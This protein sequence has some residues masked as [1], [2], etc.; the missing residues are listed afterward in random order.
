MQQLKGK[1]ITIGLEKS[2]LFL[3]AILLV[4]LIL[5]FACL[6][7]LKS[8][9]LSGFFVADAYPYDSLALEILK[10]NLFSRDFLYTYPVYPFFVSIVYYIFGHSLI[11]VGVIQI[12]LDALT[13]ILLY[14]ICL[15]IFNKKSIALLAFFM[16]ACYGLAILY[17]G[18]LVAVTLSIFINVLLIWVLIPTM[19]KKHPVHWLFSGV[20]LGLSFLITANTIIFL[21]F[22]VIWS[23]SGIKKDTRKKITN[24]LYLVL[25]ICITLAPFSLRNYKIEKNFSPFPAQGGLKFYIGNNPQARGIYET[26]NGISKV[27]ITDVKDSIALAEKEAKKDFNSFQAS[28]YWSKKGLRFIA[29]HPFIFLDLVMRK[30]ILFWNNVEFAPNV[31][32]YFCST[33]LPVLKLPL[34]S[35]GLIAPFSILGIIFVFTQKQEKAY[36]VI[37]LIFAYILYAII[38][39][40]ADRYRIPV[41]PFL[42][43]LASYAVYNFYL[44]ARNGFKRELIG[45]LV[46]LFVLFITINSDFY[47]INPK[48]SFTTARRNLG[49]VYYNLGNVYVSKAMMTEAVEHYQKAIELNP[50]FTEAYN[51][52]IL[53]YYKKNDFNQAR[54]YYYKAISRGLG[55]NPL[56]QEVLSLGHNK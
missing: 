35:F 2:D 29:S 16:Y 34:F 36:L 53:A 1:K 31:N 26:L 41:V 19:S 22:L 55:I 13:G 37:A 56:Y 17:T 12:L 25:G 24:L 11:A 54:N 50:G 10:G 15:K 44:I 3:I 6:I 40:V 51:N 48:N 21:P 27:P 30:F 14:S 32:Y 43:M 52:I 7:Q 20:I 39:F 49:L 42:I 46:L 23:V 5:R 18:F 28:L 47:P 9:H 38:F 8:S 45:C 33:I 4:S